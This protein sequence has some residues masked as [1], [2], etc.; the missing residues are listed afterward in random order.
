M[1][2]GSKSLSFKLNSQ[3]L[4]NSE[5]HEKKKEKVKTEK[6]LTLAFVYKFSVCL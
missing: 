6:V 1:L 3:Y 5:V 2:E 4:N